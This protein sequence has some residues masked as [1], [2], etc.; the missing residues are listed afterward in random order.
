V[1]GSKK[2]T[3]RKTLERRKT[4]SDTTNISPTFN[5]PEGKKGH[6]KTH[7]LS[8]LASFVCYNMQ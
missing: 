1:N 6:T 7:F 8:D 2:T 4:L 3:P 5:V